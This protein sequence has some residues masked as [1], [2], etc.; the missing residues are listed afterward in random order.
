VASRT[1]R[2]GCQRDPGMGCGRAGIDQFPGPGVYICDECVALCVEILEEQIGES[3][4]EEAEQR[5]GGENPE[6]E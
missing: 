2:P 6:D 4:R 5:L 3:W 1:L